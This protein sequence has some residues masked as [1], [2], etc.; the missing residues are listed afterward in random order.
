MKPIFQN[1]CKDFGSDLKL[2][3]KSITKIMTLS[4]NNFISTEESIKTNLLRIKKK[5]G[6]RR[7]SSGMSEKITNKPFDVSKTL[8]T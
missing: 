3:E 1:N 4:K 6:S 7:V 5:L 8:T 2:S